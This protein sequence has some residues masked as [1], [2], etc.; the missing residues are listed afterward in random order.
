[1]MS[2]FVPAPV[3]LESR[4]GG[5]EVE[6]DVVVGDAQH[7]VDARTKTRHQPEQRRNKTPP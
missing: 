7:Q 4:L 1:M 2:F 6:L 3:H 5:G